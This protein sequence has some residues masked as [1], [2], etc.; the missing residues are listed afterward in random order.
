[1]LALGVNFLMHHDTEYGHIPL[2]VALGLGLLFGVWGKLRKNTQVLEER[3]CLDV[4]AR[5]D[6]NG[7][8]MESAAGFAAGG[9]GSTLTMLWRGILW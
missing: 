3:L 7:T 8:R 5:T 2:M 6:G 4:G 1:M 9:G